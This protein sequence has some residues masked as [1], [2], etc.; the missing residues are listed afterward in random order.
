[1]AP[2]KVVEYNATVTHID[3]MTDA[4]AVFRVVPDEASTTFIPGQ[5]AVLGLNHPEKGAVQRAYSIASAPY[6]AKEYF[7]YYIRYVSKPTS[8]NPLTH[9]LW[10]LK[11]GDRLLQRPKITGHFTCERCMGNDDK[12]LR[13]LVAAGTG[14][15]P[16][17]SMV[18]EHQKHHG[19]PGNYAIVHGASY[20]KDLGYREELEELMNSGPHKRFIASIS[21][22][23]ESPEWK[24][25]TGRAE[26]HFEPGRI[27]DLDEMLGLGKGGLNPENC[28]V[29]ICGLQGT[30]AQTMMSLF[31]RGFIPAD[32]KMRKALGVPADMA[33]SVFFEQYDT[34]PVIDTRD[35]ELMTELVERLRH[36]G[37]ALER[38]VPAKT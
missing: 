22:P 9:L 20:P 37:V 32:R 17:R 11:E 26:A 1:M 14:L 25:A 4:L 6:E 12:R 13:V 29:M 34:E 2:T 24:G 28:T 3:W 15:A 36:A 35:E 10:K 33:P 38:T 5:Y 16:F 18:L 7:D 19:N 27:D 31:Y 23:R 8:D 30:I 21:R